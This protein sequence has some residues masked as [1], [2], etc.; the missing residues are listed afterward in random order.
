MVKDIKDDTLL[1][2]SN[3]TKKYKDVTAVKNLSFEIRKGEI[4]GFL[5]PNGAGKTTSINMISGLLK[6][7][8]GDVRI[9]GESI[10]ALNGRARH[11]VVSTK[12]HGMGVSDLY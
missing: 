2:V 4:F 7:D 12:Y 1:V 5:G 3:L 9:N 10:G 8:S 11:R 6:P